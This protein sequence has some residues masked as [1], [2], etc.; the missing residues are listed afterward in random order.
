MTKSEAISKV[1]A[2]LENLGGDEERYRVCVA[3][4][5]L[6]DPDPDGDGGE[7]VPVPRLKP[8][9]MRIGE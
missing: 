5:V 3:V 7:P 9:L 1:I 6:Y 4:G 2:I 8:S